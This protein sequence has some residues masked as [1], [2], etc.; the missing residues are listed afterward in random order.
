MCVWMRIQIRINIVLVYVILHSIEM[1]IT[2][3]LKAQV[4]TYALC[5]GYVIDGVCLSV[6]LLVSLFV[7]I[8]AQQIIDGFF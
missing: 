1:Q 5:G 7:N 8:I 3:L 6:G 4:I 2:M